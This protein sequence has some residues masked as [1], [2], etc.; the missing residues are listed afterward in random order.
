MQ[1]LIVGDSFA[2]DWSVKHKD[3]LGWPNLLALGHSVTNLAQ[4]GVS[5]YKIYKQLISVD[6]ELFDLVII[7]HTSPYRM[8]TRNHPVHRDNLLHAHADLIFSDI[9]YHYRSFSRFFNK[10]LRTAYNFFISHFDQEYHELVYQLLVERIE[11]LLLDKSV[12]TV[13]TPITL[14]ICVNATNKIWIVPEQIQLGNP[15]HM[16]ATNNQKLFEK[17]SQNINEI[18]QS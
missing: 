8:V 16:S 5:E 2:A 7:S 9:E 4:A 11:K 15:N 6:L 14:E 13:V 17:I 1:I 18:E 3:V 10:S 12:I